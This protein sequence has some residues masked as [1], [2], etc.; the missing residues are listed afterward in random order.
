MSKKKVPPKKTAPKKPVSTALAVRK[1]APPLVRREPAALTT[2]TPTAIET[3]EA[4][5]LYELKLTKEEEAVLSRPVNPADVLIKPSKHPIAYLSHPTYTK[6]F[7]EAFGRLGWAIAP[8]GTAQF[9]GRTVVLEHILFIHGVP[10]AK[11]TGE[12]DYLEKNR[13]QSY[14]DAIEAC[15]ASALRR[16]AKRLG[17]G[18]ELWDKT[19]LNAW[20]AENAVRVTVNDRGETKTGWRR[21]QDPPLPGEITAGRRGGGKPETQQ[22]PPEFH[23]SDDALDADFRPEDDGPRD[24]VHGAENEPITPQQ[25]ERLYKTAAKVHR[26]TTE[27]KM[28]LK[29]VYGYD[30]S[31]QIKRKEYNTI[32][33]TIE[34]PGKLPMREPGEEG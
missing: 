27:I 3:R 8:I 2:L 31:K 25:A 12:Q 29:V 34:A 6:W 23:G 32:L 20:M 1:A 4:V 21:K 11:A 19:W 7:N 30:S 33:R 13:E 9:N 17:V 24:A 26:A 15:T 16:C 10:V 5:G 14:G 18:L 28:W 22:P